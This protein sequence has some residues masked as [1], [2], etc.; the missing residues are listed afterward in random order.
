[1]TYKFMKG[2]TLVITSEMPSHI[3]SKAKMNKTDN[4]T[5]CQGGGVQRLVGMKN[6]SAL[7][8]TVGVFL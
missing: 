3:C 4:T 5:C 7:W 1:M 6:G 2:S 8:N